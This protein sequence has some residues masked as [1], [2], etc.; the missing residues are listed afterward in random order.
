VKTE[1]WKNEKPL[2]L[3]YSNNERLNGELRKEFLMGK[4]KELSFTL[5]VTN[6][7]IKQWNVIYQGLTKT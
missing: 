4:K 1:W 5:E 3:K 6:L 2:F 7:R